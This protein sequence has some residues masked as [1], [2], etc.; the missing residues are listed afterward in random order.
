LNA[1]IGN[2]PLAAR[3]QHSWPTT[4]WHLKVLEDAGLVSMQYEGRSSRLV[5][6]SGLFMRVELVKDRATKEPL[7]RKVTERIFMECVRRGLRR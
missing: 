5:Q 3:F 6:G 4:T 7:A 1:V 2:Y